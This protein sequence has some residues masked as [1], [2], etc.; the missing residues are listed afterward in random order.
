MKPHLTCNRIATE[1]QYEQLLAEAE[2]RRLT[3]VDDETWLKATAIKDAVYRHKTAAVLLGKGEPEQSVLWTN[4]E[5]GELC[6]ARADLLRE[7]SIVD[8]KTTYDASPDAFAKSIINFRYCAQRR[9]YCE[10]FSSPRFVWVAVES[11]YPHCVAV[12]CDNDEI[13]KRGIEERDPDLR[14]YAECKARNEWPGYR[15]GVREIELPRWVRSNT[16]AAF[17]P[18]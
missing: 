17:Y 3:V 5:T 8:L 2:E 15:E 13:K 7:H 10:G 12:Y 14:L 16:N 9:H 11:E 6:K 4:A 18:T 1:A